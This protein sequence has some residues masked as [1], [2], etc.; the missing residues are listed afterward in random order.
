MPYAELLRQVDIFYDLADEKLSKLASICREEI[1]GKGEIVFEENTVGDTLYI[2]QEGEV[3]ILVDPRTIGVEEAESLA[4]VNVAT[5]MR[6]QIFGEVALVDPG[7]R[8]A[9]AEC[10]T[11]TR[12]LTIEREAFD[13]LCEQDSELGYRVMRNIAADLCLKIRQTD[14]MVREQLLWRAREE[15]E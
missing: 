4:P 1:Y 12:L 7:L 13:E 15:K 10:M 11:Q 9:S 3:R 8:S 5:L 2:I 6:G 14:M